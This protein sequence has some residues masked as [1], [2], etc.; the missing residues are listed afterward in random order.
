VKRALLAG[1]GVLLLALCLAAFWLAGTES[2]LRFVLS[3]LPPAVPV[4]VAPGDVQ[5]RLVGP[6]RLSNVSVTTP[7]VQIEAGRIAA[8]WRLLALFAG[9]LHLDY[10]EG[11]AVRIRLTATEDAAPESDEALPA[12][13]LAVAIDRLTLHSGALYRDGE[14]LAEDV[15]LALSGEAAGRRLALERLELTA[16]QG[17][18]AGHARLSLDPEARWDVDLDWSIATGETPLSGRTRLT[19]RLAELSVAQELSGLCRAQASGVITGL[20]GEDASWRADLR[21]EPLGDSG[22]WPAMLAGAAAQLE[23]DGRL[24][25]SRV[26]GQLQ[27]PALIAGPV[28]VDAQAGWRDGVA[29]VESLALSFVDGGRLAASARFE[30]DPRRLQAAVSGTGLAWPVA[31]EAPAIRAPAIELRVDSAGEALRLDLSGRLQRDGLPPADV[32][33]QGRWAD[34]TLAVEQLTVRG[35]DGALSANGSGELSLADGAAR[36]GFDVAAAVRLPDRPPVDA[37]VAGRG[38]ARGVTLE[39]I[40][41]RGLGGSVRGEGQVE[42]ANDPGLR[43]GLQV[44]G[45]DPG[46]LAPQWPGDISAAV[47]LQGWP[48]TGLELELATLS[49]DLRGVPLHGRA[50]AVLAG[51]E[52][53]I[54]RAEL[55]LAQSRLE[56]SGLVGDALDLSFALEAPSL[57]D[58]H[59]D[60]AGRLAARGRVGGTRAAP[61]LTLDADGGDLRWATAE[62]STATVSAELDLS[63]ADASS[64]RVLLEGLS[65]A[66]LQDARLQLE[67]NGTPA[68]HRARLELRQ[69]DEQLDAEAA[70]A[71][72]PRRWAGALEH[73]VFQSGDEPVWTL[74]EPAEVRASATEGS[75]AGLCLDGTLGLLCA[76]GRWR[77][78]AAWEGDLVLA[79]LDLEPLSRWA[80]VGL[81]A[82]GVLSG[83]VVVRADA[84]GFRFLGGGFGLT[85]GELRLPAEGT[86]PLA[87]W[88]VGS[89][90]LDGGREAARVGLRVDLVGADRFDGGLSVG[91][92]ETDPPLDGMLDAEFSRLQV[93]AELFPEIAA[94]QGRVVAALQVGGTLGEPALSGRAEWLG[95]AMELP[96]LGLAPKD[97]HVEATAAGRQLE[98]QATAR[99]GDGRLRTDG[100]FD[101]QAEGVVGSATL[102]GERVLVV[103]VPE[104]SLQASPELRFDYT[105]KA[106]NVTG[107]VALPEGRITGLVKG[108]GVGV[109]DDEVLVGRRETTAPEGIEVTARIRA[110]VGPDVTLRV[111]G[112]RGRVEGQVVATTRPQQ[113]PSGRGEVRV[114]RGT[115]EAFGQRLNIETG[116]LVYTGGPLQNPGLDIRATRTIEE[117]T[118]GAQVRGTLQDPEISVFSDPPL[119]RA[120]ALSYLMLGKSMGELEGGEQASLNSAANSAAL[121]G[122]GLIA[123]SV[124]ERLGFDEVGVGESADGGSAVVVGKYL[125]GGLYVSYGL[126]LFDAV[127]TLKLRYRINRRLSL[128]ATSGEEAAADLYYTFERD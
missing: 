2:G 118:A 56:A 100:R 67:G 47:R 94:P 93:V 37:A 36:Y 24:A 13:P 19:G 112:L 83:Q 31:A 26:A 57:A 42:W 99:S 21:L 107:E 125:G 106:L 14:P 89:L 25:A 17:R 126:G 62:L 96:L 91:W 105:G 77:Q 12:L 34:S 33:M 123:R 54:D 81:L 9:R 71:A 122:G 80:G 101:L 60:A 55:T 11:D 4:S 78:G 121:S 29:R 68:R 111:L 51:N 41:L 50:M 115:F 120:E 53:R 22:P 5:G 10:V 90:T 108:S 58:V 35:L 97:I 23:V 46:V 88:R 87:T 38:D 84:E 65:A 117:V 92:N 6:L 74:R 103:N 128:E 7:G 76:N 16:R 66:G 82:R 124:G 43:V 127:N 85:E 3:K 114:V 72:G 104:A 49:G 28:E 69:G 32:A 61:R 110:S 39:R 79:R 1:S 95:G 102:T 27:V 18:V 20:P 40:D 119:P 73:L 44:A 8:D 70:G 45:L 64:F 75:V 63:G 113:L 48:A 116:R 30:P 109:S 59:P 52:L 86:Q 98:F 15:E